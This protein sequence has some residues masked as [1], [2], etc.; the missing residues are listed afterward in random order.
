VKPVDAAAAFDPDRLRI[1]RLS[2]GL[3]ANQLAELVGVNSSAISQYEHGYTRPATTTLAQLA[4]ALGVPVRW[5]AVSRPIGSVS[6]AGAHFRSLRASSKQE[7]GRAFA[8]AV[9]AWDLCRVLEA[10]VRLPDADVPS[11]APAAVA[12]TYDLDEIA[13][14]VRQRW[15]VPDGPVAN[16]VRLLEQHGVIVLRAQLETRRVNAFSFDF[17][18]RPLVMLGDDSGDT[19]RSRFDAAHELGHLVMHSDAEPG[20]GLLER[21]AHGF[22]AGFLLPARL[23]RDELPSRFDLAGLARLRQTWGVSI[24]ALLYRA[25][26]LGVMA[27]ATYRRAVTRMS[28]MGHRTDESAFGDLGPR[29][30]PVLLRRSIE[31]VEQSGVDLDQLAEL[32]GLP[33]DRITAVVGSDHRPR[34]E[35]S[36]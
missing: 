16:V 7:R 36:S 23:V 34:V 29:E 12:D 1:A 14:E 26:E 25:R 4:L 8:Q 5:F 20:D 10:R 31:L 11:L 24:A 9:I 3:R 27:D 28:A 22:A 13:W 19:A 6:E 33:V 21:Q 30:E 35:L 17:G 32:V 2:A 15:S 18:T